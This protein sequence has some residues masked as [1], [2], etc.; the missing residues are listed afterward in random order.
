[1]SGIMCRWP[2][3]ANL[4]QSLRALYPLRW[5]PAPRSG[6]R[7][8]WSSRCLQLPYGTMARKGQDPPESVLWPGGSNLGVHLGKGPVQ[9]DGVAV[10]YTL[11]SAAT[12]E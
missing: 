3:P 10:G 11:E 9:L 12:A 5:V 8:G 1:M 7:H 6:N 4:M 2:D